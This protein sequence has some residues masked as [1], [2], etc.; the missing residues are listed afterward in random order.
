LPAF[1]SRG[2]CG[3]VAGLCAALLLSAC[4]SNQYGPPVEGQP[5]TWGQQHYLDN[6]RHQQWTV[7][8]MAT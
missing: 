8:R 3:A 6:Q 7:D 2:R 1:F 4:A 5:K